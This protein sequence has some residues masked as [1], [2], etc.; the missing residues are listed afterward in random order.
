M[1]VVSEH[2]QHRLAVQ[3]GCTDQAMNGTFGFPYDPPAPAADLPVGA[4][5]EKSLGARHMASSECYTACCVDC[6]LDQTFLNAY[7]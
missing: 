4:K 5:S 1:R 3:F 6:L 2:M 7:S